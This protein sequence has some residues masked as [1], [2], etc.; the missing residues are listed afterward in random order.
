MEK[1]PALLRASQSRYRTAKPG[2]GPE[3]REAS[4]QPKIFMAASLWESVG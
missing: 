1:D 4:Y 2:S 3:N